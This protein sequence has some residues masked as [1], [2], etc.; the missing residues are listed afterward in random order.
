M[1]FLDSEISS[2]TYEEFFRT[3]ISTSQIEGWTVFTTDQ[4]REFQATN[5]AIMLRNHRKGRHL[6]WLTKK[7]INMRIH[8]ASTITSKCGGKWWEYGSRRCYSII[9]GSYIK[10]NIN[11]QKKGVRRNRPEFP[12]IARNPKATQ[13]G[14]YRISSRLQLP[15]LKARSAQRDPKWQGWFTTPKLQN[16]LEFRPSI[17]VLTSLSTYCSK[18][19]ELHPPKLHW[20]LLSALAWNTKTKQFRVSEC[21]FQWFLPCRPSQAQ[22]THWTAY[23][24]CSS[25]KPK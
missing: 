23:C 19:S 8:P 9:D 15:P 12:R 7:H 14:I 5:T 16:S 2:R 3:E 22:T 24:S 1:K 13:A 25:C 17:L 10:R 11:P 18:H 6:T 4:T 21:W 20:I